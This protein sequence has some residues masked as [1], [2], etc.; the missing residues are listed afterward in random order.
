[1]MDE[2][3]NAFYVGHSLCEK[4]KSSLVEIYSL[5]SQI[6]KL[7][8]SLDSVSAIADS[9]T[10]KRRQVFSKSNVTA[11]ELREINVLEKKLAKEKQDRMYF[12]INLVLIVTVN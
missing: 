3:C 12:I 7:L 9:L 6:E 8:D 1:M 4:I 10:A 2:R 5:D 11:L